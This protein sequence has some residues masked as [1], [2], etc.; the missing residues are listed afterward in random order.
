MALRHDTVIAGSSFLED[1]SQSLL[2][3][4]PSIELLI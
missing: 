3:S 4:I 1:S 2:F